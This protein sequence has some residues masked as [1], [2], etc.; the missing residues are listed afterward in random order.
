MKTKNTKQQHTI[1]P[2]IS[3][4]QIAFK[5]ATTAILLLTATWLVVKISK[6]ILIDLEGMGF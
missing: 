6:E 5:T 1:Q 2:I 4:V 3:P